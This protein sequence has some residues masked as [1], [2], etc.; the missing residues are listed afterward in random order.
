MLLRDRVVV[1]S[2][3]GPGLGRAVARAAAREGAEVVLLSRSDAFSEALI[4]DVRSF[5]RRALDVRADITNEDACARA[6]EQTLAAF[7]RVDVL[8]NNAFTTGPH[9]S[10]RGASIEKSWRAAFKV[11]VFGTMTVSRAFAEPM[12][13]RGEG[14]IVMVGSMAS[15]RIPPGLAA[16]AASKAA[17]LAAARGLAAELGPRGVRVNSVVPGHIQGPA[18]DAFF[19]ME[20]GRLSVSPEEARRLVEQDAALRRIA[21]P[22]E[23]AEAV[24]FFASPR[25]SAITG[26]SLD[27]NAGQYFD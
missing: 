2:G 26:Q 8:V 12:C 20:A 24:L 4:A 14:T 1:V 17:L 25:S 10:I 18:L 22:E 3:A 15:R 7:G 27:V 13:A 21:T 23:V 9:E 16:Y 19:Q 6:V 5:G 11:N